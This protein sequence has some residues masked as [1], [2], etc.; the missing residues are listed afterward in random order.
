MF[1]TFVA[2]LLAHLLADFTLQTNAILR[3]K[4][5]PLG[6]VLH[7]VI[8]LVTAQLALG[9][10]TS[11]ELIVLAIVHIAIDTA[12]QALGAQRLTG[13]M[14][15]QGAH[16]ITLAALAF[17]APNLWG[18]GLW[19]EVPLLQTAFIV[20]GGLVLTLTAG[21][22][23]IAL[24]MQPFRVRLR[25]NGLPDGGRIIGLLER[26][27]IF[28]LI[29]LGQPTAVGFLIAAKSILRFGTAG[30][31]QRMAEYVIIG[32]LAS[33][34]WAILCAYGTLALLSL[35]HGL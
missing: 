9:Q 2:L 23:A 14:V 1:E 27:L 31:D 7:G 30:K 25:S 5:R 26:G 19:A 15:D 22:Y 28:A 10:F 12:K 8:V 4:S 32:S 6:M 34:G 29:L 17:Y 33:F 16:V 13:F 35:H 18:T 20:L 24:L 3:G 21:Q 11:I